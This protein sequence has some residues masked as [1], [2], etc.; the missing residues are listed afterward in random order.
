VKTFESGCLGAVLLLCGWVTP[1]AA[2]TQATPPATA[3]ASPQSVEAA[4]ASATQD[5]ASSAQDGPPPQT[6]PPPATPPAQAPTQQTP[7]APQEG[8]QPATG[9]RPL[10]PPMPKVP[11][12]RMPGETGIWVG[13]TGWFPITGIAMD[14]G[15]DSNYSFSSRVIMQGDPKIAQGVD[16]GIAVGLH[17]A[18]KLSYFEAR[19]A[20][21]LIPTVPLYLWGLLYPNGTLLST[22]Y[23]LQVAKVSFEYLS[24]P[25]PVESRRFRLKTLY[26]AQFVSVRT[27]FDNPTLPLF[28]S[29]GNPLLDG[30][31]NPISYATVGSKGYFTPTLGIGTE[32]WKSKR[33]RFETS[34]TGF[35]IPHH[36]T[37]LD[38]EAS[39]NWR[40]GHW[41]LKAGIKA[42]HFKTSPTSNYF[43]RGTLYSG[44]VGLRWYSD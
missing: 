35:A 39:A 27:S 28:D 23:R 12:V 9:I 36:S 11:D 24:W 41:E 40:F 10:P 20:G 2:Q 6:T 18:L 44:I 1:G 22:S 14:K 7:A 16:L 8:G 19:A 34:T 32:Y 13:F 21:D 3:A 31:G 26:Q 37:T 29:N 15:H 38:G 4:P 25:Y 42:F 30:N 43:M 33:L 5:E 17:N